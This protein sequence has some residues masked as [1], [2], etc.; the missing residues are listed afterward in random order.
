MAT[1]TVPNVEGLRA[2]PAL[3]K[4]SAAGLS[5]HLSMAR[6]SKYEYK[7]VSQTPG[8]GRKVTRGSR[9]DL[10]IQQVG[11]GTSSTGSGGGTSSTG[12]GTSSGTG[13]TS[14]TPGSA[15][16]GGGTSTGQ[17][18]VSGGA[19][20]GSGGTGAT[21]GGPA[22]TSASTTAPDNA[23]QAAA[24]SDD[25]TDWNAFFSSGSGQYAS[26]YAA[27]AATPESGQAGTTTTTPAPGQ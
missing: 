3:A 5:G 25:Q 2:T 15:A 6:N 26:T 7:V 17:G 9:V 19:A 12:T 24:A 10:G 11:G 4:L 27:V 8:A 14:S 23:T 21:G 18:A 20:G 1:V 16:S 13:S 22:N